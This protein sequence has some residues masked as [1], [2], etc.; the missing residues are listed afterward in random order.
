[1][2]I[3]ICKI[4]LKG[5]DRALQPLLTIIVS[6]HLIIDDSLEFVSID[7][8]IEHLQTKIWI[9]HHIVLKHSTVRY[10]QFL[11]MVISSKLMIEI[12]KIL[13]HIGGKVALFGFSHTSISWYRA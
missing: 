5:N 2:H 10:G 4:I 11:K 7:L 13:T 12:F 6:I 3:L 9:L 1:M 8:I